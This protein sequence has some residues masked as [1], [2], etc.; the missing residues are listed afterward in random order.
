LTFDNLGVVVVGELFGDRLPLR[1]IVGKR[2]WA[3]LSFLIVP[4]DL[5]SQ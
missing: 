1:I 2:K 4:I 3:K 5:N